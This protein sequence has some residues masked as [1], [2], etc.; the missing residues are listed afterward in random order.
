MEIINSHYTDL[1][2][3]ITEQE[4]KY[5]HGIP[6]STIRPLM[7]RSRGSN[8]FEEGE[9]FC[10]NIKQGSAE[11]SLTVVPSPHVAANIPMSEFIKVSS[12][13]FGQDVQLPQGMAN[14]P[15]LA[16]HLILWWRRNDMLGKSKFDI[17]DIFNS[18]HKTK[19]DFAIGIETQAKRALKLLTKFEGKPVIYG[20]WGYATPEE[21]SVSGLSRGVPTLP[22]GHCHVAI[23]NEQAQNIELQTRI[24]PY[25]RLH[26]YGPWNRLVNKKFGEDLAQA[27]KGIIREAQGENFVNSVKFI[28]GQSLH[29]QGRESEYEGYEIFF[30]SPILFEKAFNC[31][32]DI[33]GNVELLYQSLSLRYT[34]FHKNKGNVE[35]RKVAIEEMQKVA[36]NFGLNEDKAREMVEFILRIIPSYGQLEKWNE[37]VDSDD[38]KANEL[39]SSHYAKVDKRRHRFLERISSKDQIP[40]RAALLRDTYEPLSPCTDHIWPVHFNAYYLFEDFDIVDDHIMV[41]KLI[42]L[43]ST[44]NKTG[45]PERVLGVR[46]SRD[47]GYNNK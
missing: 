35:V 45:I 22:D 36:R 17:F 43:P 46:L 37:E 15:F 4:K 34:E 33:A 26:H 10:G 6:T 30:D 21:I 44:L 24:D 3:I 25:S 20:T 39:L 28:R 14:I 8:I 16:P 12:Q 9:R 2:K 27:V 32:V 11:V 5:P 41:N 31:V 42:V 13:E 47:T 29:E 40:L 38:N 18:D 19:V 23:I 7:P 1:L